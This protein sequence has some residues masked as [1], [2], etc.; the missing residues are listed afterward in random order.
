MTHNKVP[1]RIE[2]KRFIWSQLSL[3]S[4]TRLLYN[5][6]KFEFLLSNCEGH[7]TAV[8][9]GCHHKQMVFSTTCLWPLPVNT[10]LFSGIIVFP[11]LHDPGWVHICVIYQLESSHICSTFLKFSQVNVH[12]ALRK[13]NKMRSNESPGQKR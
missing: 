12:E 4:I 1:L 8:V 3:S 2:N 6:S 11:L 7:I 5:H 13:G 9:H 10:R